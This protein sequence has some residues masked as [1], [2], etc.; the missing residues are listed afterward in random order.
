MKF[1][2]NAQ[3][4]ELYKYL[5]RNDVCGALL[6]DLSKAFDCLPDFLLIAK[7]HAYGFDKNPTENSIGYLIRQKQKI[8][9]NKMFNN[10][11]N[12]QQ[13]TTRPNTGSATL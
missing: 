2:L 8:K 1:V 3:N 5:Y 7:L 12:I 13:W 10:W 11:E 6:A 4:Q 9:I